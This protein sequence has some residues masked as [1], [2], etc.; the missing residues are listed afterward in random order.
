MNE[1]LK[2]IRNRRSV[3]KFKS[4]PIEDEKI[5]AILT[6]AQWAPSFMK[7]QPCKFIVVRDPAIKEQLVKA[8]TMPFLEIIYRGPLPYE[9]LTKV[10]VIIVTC[11][12]SKRDTMHYIEDGA[13][14]TQNMAL[15]AHSLG[16]A[17]YWIGL[18]NTYVENEV[19]RILEIPNDYRVISM[20]PIGVP[21]ESPK[22]ERENIDNMLYYDKYGK[23]A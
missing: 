19:K 12:D 23:T 22:K 14:A 7:L 5:Q 18:F 16:L 2:A 17:S 1:V 20:M 15:A 21:A 10:P 4:T 3:R 9:N 6:A 11:V 13:C 8:L